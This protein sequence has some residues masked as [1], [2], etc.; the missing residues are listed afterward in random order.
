MLLSEIHCFILPG[1]PVK[2]GMTNFSYFTEA[3]LSNLERNISELEKF[4]SKNKLA[5]IKNDLQ[6]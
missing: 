1:F 2:L 4:K 5:E 3:L 6:L